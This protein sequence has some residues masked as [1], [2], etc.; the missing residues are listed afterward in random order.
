MCTAYVLQ[1][2]QRFTGRNTI[3]IDIMDR[4]VVCAFSTLGQRGVFWEVRGHCCGRMASQN[5]VQA[6][7]GNACDAY[8]RLWGD[9]V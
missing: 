7:R 9:T 2:R 3:Q 6:Y 1:Y 4:Q 8:V 5:A